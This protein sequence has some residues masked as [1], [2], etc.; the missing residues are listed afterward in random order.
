[1]NPQVSQIPYNIP[2][3]TESVGG[4]SG[5]RFSDTRD[6]RQ[7]D[8]FMSTQVNLFDTENYFTLK[9]ESEIYRSLIDLKIGCYKTF[10]TTDELFADLDG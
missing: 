3:T 1:M 6:V 9:E 7:F 8:L 2:G 10:H 5:Q 4:L